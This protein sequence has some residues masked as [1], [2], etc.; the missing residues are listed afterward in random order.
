MGE[1]F[2]DLSKDLAR[3]MSRRQALWRFA[4]GFVAAV[5]TLFTGRRAEAQRLLTPASDRKLQNHRDL[6]Y[7][8]LMYDAR[9][10]LGWA[11]NMTLEEQEKAS[12]SCPPGYC[13]EMTWGGKICVPV[14]SGEQRVCAEYC[15]RHFTGRELA[16]CISRSSH[17]PTGYC[18]WNWMNGGEFDSCV[19]V[20]DGE[21]YPLMF[22][23]PGAYT[24]W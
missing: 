13:A 8:Y 4:A 1:L 15:R 21:P 6:C 2:E 18:A 11:M 24:P 14:D 12:G 10:C 19:Y 20:R 23:L 9:A 17:C 22:E 5:G 7:A 3:G 16:E